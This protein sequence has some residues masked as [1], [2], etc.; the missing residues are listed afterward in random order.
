[1]TDANPGADSVSESSTHVESETGKAKSDKGKGR[2]S[3]EGEGEEVELE[4]T[5]VNSA[6]GSLDLLVR[7]FRPRND[8]IPHRVPS[9]RLPTVRTPPPDLWKITVLQTRDSNADD[10]S[11]SPSPLPSYKPTSTTPPLTPPGLTKRASN[12]PSAAREPNIAGP[13]GSSNTSFITD[14][15]LH[16]SVSTDD[17]PTPSDD[18][19]VPELVSWPPPSPPM[20]V[21]GIGLPKVQP[22]PDWNVPPSPILAHRHL[23]TAPPPPA[24]SPS[25]VS[26]Q[27]RH[28]LGDLYQSPQQQLV[29]PYSGHFNPFA[30]WSNDWLVRSRRTYV[31]YL[32]KK[33]EKNP[34][35]PAMPSFANPIRASA[36][37][38]AWLY[39]PEGKY[40]GSKPSPRRYKHPL[41]AYEAKQRSR[42]AC[43]QYNEPRVP[44]FFLESCRHCRNCNLD[45]LCKKLLA[46]KF[47]QHQMH[48]ELLDGEEEEDDA[49]FLSLPA[50][51]ES[52]DFSESE[53]SE[54]G[55]EDSS[56]FD[57]EHEFK[58]VLENEIC[59]PDSPVI[60]DLDSFDDPDEGNEKDLACGP[61]G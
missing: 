27:P 46:L 48:L 7:S 16:T 59:V 55:L 22:Y 4:G 52:G 12:I 15:N 24:A 40:T 8:S 43:D 49:S 44:R 47:N 18:S 1:M 45:S 54:D 32:A 34:Y 3:G 2:G 23:P 9:L 29:S 14:N 56:P 36:P 51:S 5:E 21:P 42:Y 30:E 39:L 11:P 53:F 35:A 19:T 58:V 20:L 37:S 41:L 38:Q 60:R 26:P 28:I 13:S 61:M 57:D 31:D 10:P 33:R 6:N 50:L 25:L 17:I